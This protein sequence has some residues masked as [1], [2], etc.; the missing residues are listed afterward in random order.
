[1]ATGGAIRTAM[2]HVFQN[3]LPHKGTYIET[4][5]LTSVEN[6]Y[7]S[8][9]DVMAAAQQI[10]DL[11]NELSGE[12]FGR[13][14]PTH[15]VP[16]LFPGESP[17]GNGEPLQTIGEAEKV[18]AFFTYDVVQQTP[19]VR[20]INADQLHVTTTLD[21]TPTSKMPGGKWLT[22]P[23]EPKGLVCEISP[24]TLEHIFTEQ[25]IDIYLTETVTPL[26]STHNE[27]LGVTGADGHDTSEAAKNSVYKN[28]GRFKRVGTFAKQSALQMKLDD[29]S[30]KIDGVPL[31]VDIGTSQEF[32]VSRAGHSFDVQCHP[33]KRIKMLIEVWPDFAAPQRCFLLHPYVIGIGNNV[34]RRFTKA[35]L[36]KKSIKVII[37]GVRLPLECPTFDAITP[38][39]SDGFVLHRLTEQFF[40][41]PTLTLDI[42]KQETKDKLES[43]FNV[44]A[45][46]Q[47]G[48]WE[49]AIQPAEP[50][51]KIRLVPVRRRHDKLHENM[52]RNIV[53][54]ITSP[55]LTSWVEYLAGDY[56]EG[57][58]I[59]PAFHSTPIK[60]KKADESHDSYAYSD[61]S[62]QNLSF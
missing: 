40:V 35:V 38:D 19:E 48:L 49:Y 9:A 34:G 20:D 2:D 31:F 10:C 59:P 23:S 42:E 18:D 7:S 12:G 46:W 6:Y 54:V 61:V 44:V 24:L 26:L 17:R 58:Q 53:D 39:M 8:Q 29:V 13:H 57:F 11:V 22:V 41:K 5:H 21:E 16:E 3:I 32:A 43:D 50:A 60:E 37:N 45:D 56:D 52:W 15:G 28:V 36:E 4:D 30:P 1:M 47:E 51:E 27:V 25:D 55:D 33:A 14:V 62:I